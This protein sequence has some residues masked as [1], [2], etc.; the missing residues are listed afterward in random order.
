MKNLIASTIAA[1]VLGTASFAAAPAS[2]LSPDTAQAMLVLSSYLT[3]QTPEQTSAKDF[4]G[5]SVLNSAGDSIGK[6]DDLVIGGDG[7]LVAAVIGVGGFL[8]VGQKDVAIPMSNIVVSRLTDG[9][10]RLSTLETAESLKAAPVYRSLEQ[11]KAEVPTLPPGI[12][13]TAV[14]ADQ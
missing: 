14:A 12:M 10:L 6:V 5:Q 3:G 4:I 7:G 13:L 2:A 9:S 8:G 11:Q 1:L